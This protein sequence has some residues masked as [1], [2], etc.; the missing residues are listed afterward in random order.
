MIMEYCTHIV[1]ETEPVLPMG[2][3]PCIKLLGRRLVLLIIKAQIN[4]CRFV[5]FVSVFEHLTS[6]LRCH[7]YQAAEW[8]ADA[9][10]HPE[11]DM[12]SICS[13][14]IPPSFAT[15]QNSI[16]SSWL[17]GLPFPISLSLSLSLS[18]I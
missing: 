8:R 17:L 18:D 9:K 7:H 12:L 4:P 2:M 1:V 6:F 5:L 15:F 3:L 16:V 11:K 14:S 10:P 13:S